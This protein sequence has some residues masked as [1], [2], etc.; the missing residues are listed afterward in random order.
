MA[1]WFEGVS[2]LR[3]WKTG[4]KTLWLVPFGTSDKGAGLDV[5]VRAISPSH[6]TFVFRLSDQT[7][8]VKIAGARFEVTEEAPL[9]DMPT[10]RFSRI[11]QIFS[12]DGSAALIGEYSE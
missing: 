5:R 11:V 7:V 4:N 9:E 12:P 6:V 2:I 8:D 1:S 10:G 3:S